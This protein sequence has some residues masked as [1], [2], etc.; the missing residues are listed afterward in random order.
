MMRT[1]PEGYTYHY[2]DPK[3][4]GAKYA[5]CEACGRENVCEMGGA[6]K[7]HH[8]ADCPNARGGR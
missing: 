3:F 1:A 2:E 6:E 8:T 5:R 4:G 7:I